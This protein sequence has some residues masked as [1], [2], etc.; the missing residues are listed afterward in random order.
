MKTLPVR[1]VLFHVDGHTDGYTDMTK[2]IA[3]FAVLPTP[4]KRAAR[5][6]QAPFLLVSASD[7]D[8]LLN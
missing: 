7:A 3:S 4:L 8:F 6:K 5:T 2:Q 1:A